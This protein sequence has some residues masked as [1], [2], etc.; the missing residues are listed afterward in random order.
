MAV[1]RALGFGL[2]TSADRPKALSSAPGLTTWLATTNMNGSFPFVDRTQFRTAV[3]AWVEDNDS[4]PKASESGNYLHNYEQ[5]QTYSWEVHEEDYA[6]E[7]GYSFDKSAA[8]NFAF[9]GFTTSLEE[10]EDGWPNT[11]SKEEEKTFNCCSLVCITL[12]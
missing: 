12:L 2:T 3:D 5:R 4:N 10:L 1:C 8:M 9:C 11:R 7:T 6:W